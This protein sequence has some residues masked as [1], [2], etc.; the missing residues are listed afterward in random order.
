[1]AVFLALALLPAGAIAIQIGLNTAASRSAALV[2]NTS[3]DAAAT[4]TEASAVFS[5][6]SDVLRVLGAASDLRRGGAAA[7]QTRLEDLTAEYQQFGAI[8]VMTADGH[9]RCSVPRTAPGRIAS[10]PVLDRAKERGVL[11]FG[12]NPR[13]VLTGEPM[14]GGSLPLRDSAGRVTGYIG[15][16]SSLERL[17]AA[18]AASPLDDGANVFLVDETGA[19]IGVDLQRGDTRLAASLPRALVREH[20]TGRNEQIVHEGASVLIAPLFQPDIYMIVAWRPPSQ[21]WSDRLAFA[22]AVAA[23]VLMWAVAIAVGWLA[24]E[25]FVARPLSEIEALARDY[26]RGG[27]IPSGGAFASAPLEIRSLFRTLTAMAKTLRAREH[28]LTE[29]LKEERALLREV[30][31]RVKNNLQ[32]VASLLNI[33]A[34]GASDP[35]EARGLARAH[36]RVQLLSIVHQRIYSSGTVN[37]VR[38]DEITRDIARH[39]VSTRSGQRAEIHL[40]LKLGEVRCD[41]DSAVPMG[42][43]IGESLS[44]ALDHAPESGRETLCLHLSQ[45]SEGAVRF[46]IN[47]PLAESGEGPAEEGQLRLVDA[48]ARQLG[49][50]VGRQAVGRY[51]V[52]A[53]TPTLLPKVAA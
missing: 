43:L 53:E 42:F 4:V 32:V 44:N 47:G 11:S 46:T 10:G 14:I 45:D 48:F 40:E 13:S 49:A 29:A 22:F 20:M 9:F 51:R 16:A 50:S 39:M 8:A 28:R 1:M 24:I 7:C 34:R 36:D 31:H 52:W 3:A 18:V 23:P 25:F 30:H 2:Q 35:A 38:L 15:L 6:M 17:Q 5:E 33:Q 12:F 41:V 27:D 37:E 19:Q 21:S 26:A